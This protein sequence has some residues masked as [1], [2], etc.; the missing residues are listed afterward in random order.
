M[1]RFQSI[2]TETGSGLTVWTRL[3]NPLPYMTNSQENSVYQVPI[4]RWQSVR[5]FEWCYPGQT[6]SAAWCCGSAGLYL[7]A[8]TLY[9]ILSKSH[10][11]LTIRKSHYWAFQH[12]MAFAIHFNVVMWQ[13][14]IKQK[15]LSIR[16]WLDGLMLTASWKL[17]SATCSWLIAVLSKSSSSLSWDRVLAIIFLSAIL[18][19]SPRLATSVEICWC[20]SLV[21]S[22]PCIETQITLTKRDTKLTVKWQIYCHPH[23]RTRATGPGRVHLCQRLQQVKHYLLFVLGQDSV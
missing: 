4:W 16:N 10:K 7:P 21:S 22:D 12:Q 3:M 2:S 9:Q 6:S 11:N 18:T 23:K 15:F 5:P 17:K 1:I 20:F 19:K 14:Q 8:E 13:F